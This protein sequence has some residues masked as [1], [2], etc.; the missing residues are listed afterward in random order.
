MVVG[1]RTICVS[2]HILQSDP[3]AASTSLEGIYCIRS[4]N[5]FC[6][7]I[8]VWEND[9]SGQTYL[10]RIIYRH[11]QILASTP[12]IMGTLRP[13]ECPRNIERITSSKTFSLGMVYSKPLGGKSRIVKLVRE[14]KKKKWF[15]Y[16]SR[17]V[18]WKCHHQKK[19][20]KVYREF[21][22]SSYFCSKQIL[23]NG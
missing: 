14:M 22:Y 11:S 1:S 3:A 18:Y 12:N 20:K 15:F 5:N 19:K 4:C 9:L 6:W 17:T 10:Y 8:V 2:G 13:A 21:W 7:I 23:G 16:L